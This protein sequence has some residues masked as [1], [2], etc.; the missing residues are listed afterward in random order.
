MSILV[1][2]LAASEDTNSVLPVTPQGKPF[3]IRSAAPAEFQSRIRGFPL[4]GIAAF[5]KPTVTVAVPNLS[6]AEKDQIKSAIAA[7]VQE[8]L[9]TYGMVFMKNDDKQSINSGDIRCTIHF[10]DYAAKGVIGRWRIEVFSLMTNPRSN[11]FQGM[12]VWFDQE[13]DMPDQAASI[14]IENILKIAD[15]LGGDYKLANQKQ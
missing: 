3:P 14:P 13:D 15:K 10:T 8:R 1:P 7:Q 2:H 12:R 9:E 4:A 11:E 5:A 6:E